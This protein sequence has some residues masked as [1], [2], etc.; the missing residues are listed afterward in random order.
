MSFNKK[1]IAILLC[2]MDS[3]DFI[4]DQLNSIRN[5]KEINYDLFIGNDGCS[6][7]TLKILE[8][9][10][11]EIFIGPKNG[12]AANFISS[13]RK[14][15]DEYDYYCFC[16]HDDIW[17]DNKLKVSIETLQKYDQSLPNLYCGR[18]QLIN[19]IGD[20]IGLSPLFKK[21]PSF[22]N[23]LVQSIAGGNTM[24][25][26][27]ETKKLL[28]KADL[29]KSIISH[30]WLTYILVT[31]FNGNVFYDP[32]PQVKYRIHK[33]NLIGSNVGIFAFLKRCKQVLNGSWKK[34]ID[35]NISQISEII[36]KGNQNF[37]LFKIFLEVKN[38]R[39][40][41][42]KVYFLYKYKFYRQTALGSLALL[43]M[44]I[45]KKL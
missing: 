38:G 36:P 30:D 4:E 13:L 9:H 35:S 41:F 45:F 14:I 24:T 17:M 32:I 2:V 11:K 39:N 8:K 1:K 43:M 28:A 16:D 10:A 21:G 5:Q 18:T 40:I 29:N 15:S 26:N 7:K 12:F 34:W 22:A 42:K 19:N 31:A 20:K 25:F 44:I 6:N 23:A 37:D 3:D 33:T 27:L